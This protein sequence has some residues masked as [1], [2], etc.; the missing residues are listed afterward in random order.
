MTSALDNLAGSGKP[1]A[2]EPAD[3]REFEGLKRSGLA[4]LKDATN[5]TLSLESRLDLAYNPA[6]GR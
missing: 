6:H 1:L 2:R 3:A 5:E 4:R